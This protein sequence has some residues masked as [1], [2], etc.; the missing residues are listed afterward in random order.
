MVLTKLGDP[1]KAER[2]PVT[3]GSAT[4]EPQRAAGRAPGGSRSRP[5]RRAGSS[6]RTGQTTP[7]A[8]PCSRCATRPRPLSVAFAQ[9]ARVQ[10]VGNNSALTLA[11]DIVRPFGAVSS[12]GVHQEPPLPFTGRDVYNKNVSSDFGRCLV[13]AMFPLALEILRKRQD[14]FGGVGQAASLI[15]R[16]VSRGVEREA[17]WEVEQGRGC[18]GRRRGGCR[19]SCS[20]RGHA[21]R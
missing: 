15:D 14:M 13:R 5:S 19:R 2:P 11:Y 10:V 1:R 12:V 16:I 9:P 18:W 8:T 6:P 20:G 3:C 7:G 17:G 4:V 21:L